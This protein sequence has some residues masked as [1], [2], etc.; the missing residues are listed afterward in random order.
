[1]TLHKLLN[2]PN[3]NAASM[4]VRVSLNHELSDLGEAIVRIRAVQAFEHAGRFYPIHRVVR[5]AVHR[6]LGPLFDD[7]ALNMGCAAQRVE[8]GSLVLDAPGV[9]VTA[10][11]YN[12]GEY[13]SCWF[14]VWTDTLARFDE[15]RQRLLRVAGDQRLRD[16]MFTVDWNFCNSRG[17]LLSTSFD[18]LADESLLD[19]AYPSLGVPVESFVDQYLAARETVLIL[20]GPPGMGKTRLVRAVLAAMSRRKGDSAKIMYTADKRALENDEIFV[21]F[22]TGSHDAFVIED[23]D[24]LLKARTS[25]NFELHR[26]LGVADG[27]VR[28]QSRKVI[29]TTNL[30]NIN[31]IDDALLRPGRCFAV[32]TLRSLTSGE[33]SRLAERICGDDTPRADRAKVAMLAAGS[34]NYSVA[35]VYRACA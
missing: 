33:A 8:V 21:D 5:C 34:K 10:Q 25:G 27:V 9:F 4:G 32:K 26:F 18:E 17:V 29:F 12:K 7:L 6:K 31:D 2:E 35:Q 22:I 3:Q 20:Q 16:R 14:G 30:P 11:G 1:M 24:H 19:E 13:V 15:I 28:A 23:A